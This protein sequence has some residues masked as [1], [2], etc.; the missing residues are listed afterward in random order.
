M[1][2]FMSITTGCTPSARDTKGTMMKA[3]TV[4]MVQT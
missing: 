3:G 4:M 1:A 2:I